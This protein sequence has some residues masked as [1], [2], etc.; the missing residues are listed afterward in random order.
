MNKIF[1]TSYGCFS[2]F[3]RTHKKTLFATGAVCA[4]SFLSFNSVQKISGVAEHVF[5]LHYRKPAEKWEQAL[6]IGNGRLGGMVFGGIQREQI[7]LNE[8][9]LWSGKR[10]VSD[11]PEAF[12]YLPQVRKLLVEKNYLGAQEL[13][14][15]KLVC[16]GKG[17]APGGDYGCY[18]T[19]GDL[20]IS[21]PQ[22]GPVSDYKR[23]LDLHEAIATTTFYI[24]TTK[25]IREVFVSAPDQVL[26]LHCA[27]LER[28]KINFS[29]ELS[30]SESGKVQVDPKCQ[31]MILS[32]QLQDEKGLKYMARLRMVAEG[33]TV[34]CTE[35]G[36]QIRDADSATIMIAAATDYQGKAYEAVTRQQINEASLKTYQK[37]KAAHIQDYQRYFN[38]VD[39]NL[40]GATEVNQLPTDERLMRLRQ[41]G[42]DPQLSALYFQYGRYLLISSSRACTLPA[43]LQGIWANQIQTPWNSDFHLNINLQM[44]Y[45]PAEV[46]NLA[47]CHLP[48]FD[49]MNTL[50]D[51]GKTTAKVH[52]DA[53]GWVVHTA[54]NIWGFT[55]PGEHPK[56]GLFPAAG[57]WLCHHL[58]EHYLFG[59]DREFLKR[60]YPMMKES[61]LFYLDYLVQEPEHGWLVTSPSSS[62]ENSF[63]TKNGQ[64]AAVCMGPSM[65]QQIIFNLFSQVIAAA[66]ILEVDTAFVA[67]LIDARARLAP[68]Q[69]G[70]HGQLQ[71]WLEDFEEFEPGHRHISHLFGLYPGN[72]FSI[73]SSP[74]LAQAARRS[75]ERRLEHG[76]G[77]T[78]WSRAWIIN[79]WARLGEGEKAHE[80]L[81]K[82]LE[83]STHPNL[84]DDHPPFQ[85]DGNF[86]GT[87]AI[88][89]MVLQSHEGEISLLPALPKA[90]S[91]G[92]FKGLRARGGIEIDLEWR[93]GK[94]ATITLRT[95][96]SGSCLL[97]FPKQQ[98]LSGLHLE[99]EF[100]KEK[101][102][103]TLLV[104]LEANKEYRLSLF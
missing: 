60:A 42:A 27:C 38:R 97:R 92:Y 11:N 61:A 52:Y 53:G 63:K 98:A 26:V 28:N 44:N 75:L 65:D 67:K 36:L 91:T 37:L 18:Q 47:E 103:N 45:W 16:Q 34:S 82:L 2:S 66:K 95:T 17:T 86:G 10:Q 7:Q 33:G 19:L 74:K 84:F 56:W 43:N 12:K 24:G 104:T 46:A 13:A 62:P 72:Q 96:E 89:E 25:F 40:G 101:G 20:T 41:G 68:P 23:K 8:E 4:V 93:N 3:F 71:E 21:F 14:Y 80:H 81:V 70:K 85:I 90:W 102:I 22:N 87:A 59:K 79:F 94:V 69:I 78:G 54:T 100:V 49:L 83:K 1:G 58:W 50:R 57:G 39:L 48:L 64:T 31:E 51:P 35:S 76:G 6:P 73:H 32:G 9:T 88:A 15:A 77:H 30:R 55:S 99:Q 29:L 5:T